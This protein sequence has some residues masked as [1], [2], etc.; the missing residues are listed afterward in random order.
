MG[1]RQSVKA[2]LKKNKANIYVNIYSFRH[3][4]Y[5]TYKSIYT[6]YF[7]FIYDFGLNFPA[8]QIS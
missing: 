4:A 2:Y 7:P 6:T 3:I 5:P 8:H 1:L